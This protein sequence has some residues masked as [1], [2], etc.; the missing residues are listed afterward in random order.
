[1]LQG[2]EQAESLRSPCNFVIERHVSKDVKFVLVDVEPSKRDADKAAL[3]LKGDAAAIAQQLSS[4]LQGLDTGRSV[5]WRQQLSQK[6]SPT[7]VYTP[8]CP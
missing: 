4:A 7:D 5:Q 2:F 1:M 6:A 3:V 8:A